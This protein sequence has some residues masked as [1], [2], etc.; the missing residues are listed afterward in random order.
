MKNDGIYSNSFTEIDSHG[1]HYVEVII[2]DVLS[3]SEI[4][5]T[6][7]IQIPTEKD[8]GNFGSKLKHL[9][10]CFNGHVKFKRLKFTR[11]LQQMTIT[12]SMHQG[13]IIIQRGYHLA[14]V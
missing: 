2:E 4:H 5:R 14:I 10:F 1:R 12:I 7:E 9:Q 3:N 11:L 8:T 6:Y 13:W